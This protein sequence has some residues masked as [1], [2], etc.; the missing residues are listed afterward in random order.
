MEY[1]PSLDGMTCHLM[2]EEEMRKNDEKKQ[3]SMDLAL[4]SNGKQTFKGKPCVKN[5]GGILESK[6]KQGGES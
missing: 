6:S 4:I 3:D 1:V 5:K 2:L